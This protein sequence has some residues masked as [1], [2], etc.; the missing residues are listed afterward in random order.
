MNEIYIEENEMSEMSI[1]LEK[2]LNVIDALHMERG[3]QY[4]SWVSQADVA[5]GIKAA[6]A[7]G[8]SYDSLTPQVREKLD[9]IANKLSRIVNGN[10]FNK[11]SW[12][13][14]AGYATL[15]S[16]RNPD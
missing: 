16:H 9:M 14:I 13:D 12:E 6:Y 8:A 7:L 1:S 4:G 10:Q 3:K 2:N 15:P 11:D 5:Q